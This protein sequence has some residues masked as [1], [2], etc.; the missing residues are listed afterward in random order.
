MIFAIVI[1]YA[2][3]KHFIVRGYMSFLERDHNFNRP[4]N[5]NE[6]ANKIASLA[7]RSLNLQEMKTFQNKYNYIC[8][9]YDKST[10]AISSTIR[11][12][13]L[14]Q[15]QE[16]KPYLL[17]NKNK[18]LPLIIS[19]MLN[20]DIMAFSIFKNLASTTI[21]YNKVH[22][23]KNIILEFQKYG[24]AEDGLAVVNARHWLETQEAAEIFAKHINGKV[25]ECEVNDI[26]DIHNEFIKCEHNF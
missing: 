16:W 19:K 25:V 4:L 24:G 20:G 8:Q 2:L 23:N 6:A 11:M 3:E 26:L 12:N 22:N 9:M 5:E 14:E 21:D 10:L 7:A 13:E 18:V 15:F 17:E 1:I